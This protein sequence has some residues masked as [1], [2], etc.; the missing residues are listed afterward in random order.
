M[1]SLVCAMLLLSRHAVDALCSETRDPVGCVAKGCTWC[2][3]ATHRGCSRSGGDCPKHCSTTKHLGDLASCPDLPVTRVSATDAGTVNVG[4]GF[5]G[6]GSRAFACTFGWVRGLRDLGLWRS[7]NLTV[8]GISGA[9]WFL[10]PF[11][12]ASADE[13]A[14]LGAYLEPERLSAKMIAASG[15]LMSDLP[16]AAWESPSHDASMA[17]GERPL[18]SRIA[19]AGPVRSSRNAQPAS[20]ASSGRSTVRVL[21]GYGAMLLM[22]HS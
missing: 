5:S 11:A 22:L 18:D 19:N 20:S 15:G 7:D 17:S 12:Y 6:G 21:G 10:A 3:A 14:L 4:V 9:A 13:A 16:D 1:R 2:A 8:A